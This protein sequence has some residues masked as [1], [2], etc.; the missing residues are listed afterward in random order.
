MRWRVEAADGEMMTRAHAR[1]DNEQDSGFFGGQQQMAVYDSSKDGGLS[2]ARIEQQIKI[3]Q[4]SGCAATEEQM[5]FVARMM[6]Y[7]K[8][9]ERVQSKSN[10]VSNHILGHCIFLDLLALVH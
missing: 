5:D 6:E 2:D 1:S 3:W 10:G 8:I 4:K 7:V 9:L